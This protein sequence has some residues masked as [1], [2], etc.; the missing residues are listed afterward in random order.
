MFTETGGNAV[1]S[2]LLVEADGK[3]AGFGQSETVALEPPRGALN[4]QL[5]VGNDDV[6]IAAGGDKFSP[7]H[8]GR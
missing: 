3:T 1:D 5:P 6:G 8:E 2:R 7:V 4:G